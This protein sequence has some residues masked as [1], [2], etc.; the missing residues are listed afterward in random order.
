MKYVRVITSKQRKELEQMHEP[1]WPKLSL[2]EKIMATLFGSKD[3]II[4]CDRENQEMLSKNA[5]GLVLSEDGSTVICMHGGSG[6]LCHGCA[7]AI[8][9]RIEDK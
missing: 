9:E 3:D 1:Y 6:W 5:F 4:R 8:C 2:Y 7:K